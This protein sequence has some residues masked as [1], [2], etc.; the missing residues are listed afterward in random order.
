MIASLKVGP[1][2]AD[3]DEPHRAVSALSIPAVD[4]TA[5]RTGGA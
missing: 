2:A 5:D 4:V 3:R 1:A